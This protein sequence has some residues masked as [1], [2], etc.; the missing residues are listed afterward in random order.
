M[1]KF[2]YL[3]LFIFAGL[4]SLAGLVL[5]STTD[6]TVSGYAWNNQSGWINFGWTNGDVHVTDSGLTGYAWSQNTG[7]INLSPGTAG[8]GVKNDG[9][10]NLSGYA[11]DEGSGK[12]NFSGVVI[13]SSGTFSGTATGDNSVNINFSCSSCNVQTDWRPASARTPAPTPT[14]TPT[15]GGG[16]VYGPP[17]LPLKILINNGSQ[18]TN[19]KIV[20]L[21]FDG[22][23]DSVQIEISN[24]SD[25]LNAVKE[26]IP[27]KKIWTLAGG[28]GA[29][30]IYAKF[31]SKH[32][33][34]S[35]AIFANIIL[36]TNPP[37]IVISNIKSQYSSD[38]EII[39][40]GKTEA[41]AEITALIDNS[42]YGIFKADNNGDWL[43]SFGKMPVGNHHIEFSA[44]DLAQNTGKT[45]SA[46]F[47]V[48]QAGQA[49]PPGPVS[50]GPLLGQAWVSTLKNLENGIAPFI[51]KIF[52]KKELQPVQVVTVP[53]IAPIAFSKSWYPL[54]FFS[55]NRFVLAPLP[56]DITLLAQKIPQLNTTFK[57]VG[58]QKITDVQK[59]AA[60]NLKL[61][62]LAQITNIPSS[63]VATTGFA[64]PK[65]IPIAKLT[66]IAKSK[67]PT[68]IVFTKAGAGLID[69][70]IALSVN[71]STGQTQQT[72]KTVANSPLQLVVREDKPVKQITGY[73]IFESRKTNQV[74]E[75]NNNILLNYLTAS[76]SFANPD[77]TVNQVPVAPAEQRLVLAYFAYQPAG[78][79]VYTAQINAPAVSGQYQIITDIDYQ[80]PAI[81]SK[82][83]KLVT[84]V[85]PEGYIYEKTGNKETRILG[86]VVSLY[87]LN[88]KTKQYELWSAKDY[89]QENPQTTDVSGT[90]SFLVPDGYYYLRVDTPGYLSYDGKPFNVTE[91]SGIHINIELKTQ[92]WWLNIIDW[93]TALLVVVVL[94]LLYNFYQDKTRDKIRMILSKKS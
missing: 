83:I 45:I 46:D 36:D 27:A 85:D 92:Y 33:V 76:L 44:T 74:S 79:G 78:N 12:I 81:P 72:I 8:W 63:G 70:N 55:L 23:P 21:V 26:D 3:F 30:T 2:A 29:K 60:A 4:I 37:S 54:S 71:K 9:E 31:Y 52:N 69:F 13:S 61:P 87:W 43:V 32:Q 7:R 18:Y 5:A 58:V 77:F 53:K 64:L 28:D 24:S 84:V 15:P 48:A 93:K 34:P 39:I 67:I 17:S 47:S 88:P 66:D 38:E 51:A 80:D 14:P 6:G 57:Q 25:F 56:S 89:Q 73:I 19:N 50:L 68:D 62:T 42:R 90:Y 65:G 59:I 11:W 49:K 75:N 82:E 35:Q 1:A 22:G 86:A 41:N 40:S 91:G 10:G 20:S 94:M 16:I